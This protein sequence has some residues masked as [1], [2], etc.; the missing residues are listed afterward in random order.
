MRRENLSVV[1][2]SGQE[3]HAER[4]ENYNLEASIE[5]RTLLLRN[6]VSTTRLVQRLTEMGVEV[7]LKSFQARM[8]RGTFTL[9]FYL[10]C[11]RAVQAKRESSD[12]L[13][14]GG[15]DE[16][17]SSLNSKALLS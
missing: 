15:V 12:D 9:A 11:Q 14:K 10:Q 5:L 17:A 4:P 8:R 7:T 16:H 13:P 1:N 6:R 3:G 2:P